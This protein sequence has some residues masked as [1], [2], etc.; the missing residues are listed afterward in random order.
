MAR[1][2]TQI[3]VGEGGAVNVAPLGTALPADI[4]ATLDPAFED[5]GWITQDGVALTMAFSAEQLMA[6]QSGKPVRILDVDNAVTLGFRA[7]QW[8]T[9]IFE[10]MLGATVADDPGPPAQK[11]VTFKE[12]RP[13]R[14]F[15][16]DV[17]DGDNVYRWTI[18]K[19]A[20]TNDPELTHIRSDSAGIDVEIQVLEGTFQ[21]LTDDPAF[22]ASV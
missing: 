12:S 7:H 6:W 8:N 14:A 4:E 1:D 19:G 11:I 5:L 13:E 21:M 16:F 20:A 3:V 2:A 22:I 10:L 9:P 18:Q 17:V 15:V